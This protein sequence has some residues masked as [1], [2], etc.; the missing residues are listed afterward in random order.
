MKYKVGDKVKV[1]E[2]LEVDKKYGNKDF[3]DLMEQYKGKIVTIAS[4][5][6][7][8]YVIEEDNGTWAWTD[9][10]LESIEKGEK[11]NMNIEKL[12]EEYKNKMD[13]LM[14]EYKTKVKEVTK[15][16]E[17]YI[18]EGQDYF[19]VDYDFAVEEDRYCKGDGTDNRLLKYGNMYPYTD[20]NKEEVRKEVE[21]IAERRKLQSEMEL[22]AR[23]NNDC[24]IDWNDCEQE[25][26][27]LC[28]NYNN[29]V[30]A[31]CHSGRYPN[32]TYYTSREVA[33][34]AL[35]KFGDRIR[36]LYL[37]EGEE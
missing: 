3:I 29:N 14:E 35:E 22:F 8:Y 26:W 10:M 6:S 33:E 1:R 21:L 15:K 13:A 37:K 24:E 36:E 12:N 32:V 11:N 19:Y 9:E 17:P 28:I 20:E 5:E 30:V 23:L 16:E 18:N 27:F 31:S 34:K 4:I 25:K 2:D 7:N